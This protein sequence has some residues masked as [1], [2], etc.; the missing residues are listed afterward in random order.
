MLPMLTLGLQ[1]VG[2]DIL[3]MSAQLD[4]TNPKNISNGSK[5]IYRGYTLRKK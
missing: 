3:L 4:Q 2:I 1:E 5:K